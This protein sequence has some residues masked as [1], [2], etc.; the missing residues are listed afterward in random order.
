MVGPSL[1]LD[2]VY[3]KIYDMTHGNP[4]EPVTV[5]YYEKQLGSVYAPVVKAGCLE[6]FVQ[7]DYVRYTSQENTSFMV[8]QK[9]IKAWLDWLNRTDPG[10][11]F[12]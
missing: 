10:K 11:S 2:V 5:K 7:C 12:Y 6:Y 1:P 3:Q 4:K 9:G 8:T